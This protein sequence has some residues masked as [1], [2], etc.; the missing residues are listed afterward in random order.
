M[1][2]VPSFSQDSHPM[3]TKTETKTETETDR[4]RIEEWPHSPDHHTERG[5]APHKSIDKR[6]APDDANTV[7]AWLNLAT[8]T[9][10]ERFVEASRVCNPRCISQG[11]TMIIERH[12]LA[13]Q[14]HSHGAD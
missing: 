5:T 8:N 2:S 9:R 14:I 7:W 10:T 13:N 11:V 1:S 12:K 6:P 4:I 3:P